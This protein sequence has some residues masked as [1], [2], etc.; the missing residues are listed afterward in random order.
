MNKVKLGIDNLNKYINEF[1]GKRVGLVT[2][3]TGI[4]SAFESTIDI[5]NKNTNL[6]SLYSPEHGIRG[7]IQAG[8]VIKDY[9]DDKTGINV[10]SLYGKNKKPTYEMIKDIDII[11]FDIQDV[12][13]RFYTYLYTMAY[14]M[15]SCKDYNK[16]FVI[17][18][19]PNPIGG[20][21]VEG[22]ILDI[23]FK[24][25]IGLYPIPQ[26]YAL[27][28]G[29]IATLFNKEFKIDCNLIVAKMQ[30]WK[31]EMYFEDTMLPWVMPSP[32]I[33]TIDTALVYVGTC[34]FEGTNISEGRGTTKPFELIGAPFLNSF[35]LSEEMNSLNLPGVK[36]T[37]A[38]FI[39]TFSKY[40]NELCKGVQIHV[41][42]RIKFNSLETGLTLFYYIRHFSKENFYF[43]KPFTV[44]KKSLVDYNTGCEYIRDG[45]LSLEEIISKWRKESKK[46][47]LI[48]EKYHLY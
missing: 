2:N 5:L 39:P 46:F 35:E 31:R 15:K 7:D 3:T 36:F 44:N 42:D 17:F 12:G 10:F 11:A 33:P 8:E 20:V 22:N 32:N 38:H 28:I 37:P 21:K 13:A 34:I 30:G 18:D 9:I 1:Q 24:S 14:V 43:I 23:N 6:V 4:D 27:T 26:R 45:V 47:K 25:F 16:T 41:L 48:K 40:K 19:R 29:E